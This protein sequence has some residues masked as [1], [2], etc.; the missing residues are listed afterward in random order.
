MSTRWHDVAKTWR[1]PFVLQEFNTRPSFSEFPGGLSIAGLEQP[2][3]V[4]AALKAAAFRYGRDGEARSRQLCGCDREPVLGEKDRGALSPQF[5]KAAETLPAA[6]PGGLGDVVH[7]DGL[8]VVLLD[9]FHHLAQGD[10][11]SLPRHS[12]CTGRGIPVHLFQYGSPDAAHQL[13]G[14]EL[15]V[16][17][18]GAEFFK[19]REQP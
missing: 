11:L 13:E 5:L 19:L 3:K 15:I 8:P 18:P 17:L 6:D 10:Q 12:G 1:N 7:T 9:E 16:L 4:T 14:V 2:G